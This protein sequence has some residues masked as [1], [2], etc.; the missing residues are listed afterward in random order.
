MNAR[1]LPALVAAMLMLGAGNAFSESNDNARHWLERMST[2][3]SQ[4]DY[5]GTFVYV[6]GDDVVTM[7]ITHVA[8]EAGVRERLVSMS[9][10]PREVLRDSNGV[11][12]VL[13]DDHSVLADQPFN[14]SF[15]PQLPLD[16]QERAERWYA[17]TLG[18]NGRIAGRTVR[19]V[20]VVP[21]DDYRYG[22]TLW[23]EERSALLLK[24]ELVDHQR[25]PLARLM[26]T[27]FR[28]GSEVDAGE[29]VPSSQLKKFRT[30]ESSLPT[31]H[32]Q[33]S[34]PPRWQ[35]REL[36]PGFQLTAHRLFGRQDRGL[37]E[38]LVYSDGLAAVSVY[39]ESD[40]EVAA[41]KTGLSRMGTTHAFSRVSD[42][43][44]I[45]VIGDVPEATVR[46]IGDG[47]ARVTP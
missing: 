41:R 18:G 2:A 15:F 42:D 8:D 36:P 23:L 16:E 11:R 10:V 27:D 7:R 19:G 25:K 33:S 32:G 24:W 30:V 45:T 3:M 26:F 40:G 4:M 12:W 47:V 46:Y 34:D 14:R 28:M 5:Q 21:R 9:G 38:H 35:P 44:L 37:F 17:L 29:L 20:N 39:V 22:Y 13:G 31:G 6:Q 1:M 43:V